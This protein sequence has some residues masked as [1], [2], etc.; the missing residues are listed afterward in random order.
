MQP[1]RPLGQPRRDRS[2]PELTE[3]SLEASVSALESA[4]VSDATQRTHTDTWLFCV[5]FPGMN[6]EDPGHPL[7]IML[8]ECALND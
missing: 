7:N 2:K 8:S 3:Q 6:V 1:D 5:E 4:I